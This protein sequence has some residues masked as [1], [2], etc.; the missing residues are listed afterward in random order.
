MWML[1]IMDYEERADAHNL[2][3]ITAQIAGL[4]FSVTGI[5]LLF[6]SFSGRRKDRAA[7]K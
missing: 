3:L 5:W 2:L 6:Y 7:G 1:H 4:I